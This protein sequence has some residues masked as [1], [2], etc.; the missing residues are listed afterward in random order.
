MQW[1]QAGSYLIQPTKEGIPV[2]EIASV[3]GM[4]K[5]ASIVYNGGDHALFFRNHELGIILDCLNE[6]AK[7]LLNNVSE[8][9]I[10]E[11]SLETG[12]VAPI[13]RV[14]VMHYDDE[15]NIELY[16]GKEK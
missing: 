4:P 3:S 13:Y 10:C 1:I 12:N 11:T 5:D 8:A 6:V 14:P 2:I 9:A 16:R 7:G 15:I